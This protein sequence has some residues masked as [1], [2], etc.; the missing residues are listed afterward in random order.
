MFPKLKIKC[1]APMEPDFPEH[2][3]WDK[4]RGFGALAP[5]GQ[6]K[7]ERPDMHSGAAG[8]EAPGQ[9]GKDVALEMAQ[10]ISVRSPR[11]KGDLS[12]AYTCS[13]EQNQDATCDASGG[14]VPTP[15]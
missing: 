8:R 10:R 9:T 7:K 12:P 13:T 11:P 3:Q 15:L 2:S 14:K 5:S 6:E 4:S 1:P